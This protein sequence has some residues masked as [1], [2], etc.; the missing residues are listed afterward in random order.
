[1]GQRARF[2]IGYA[3]AVAAFGGMLNATTVV[4]RAK[5]ET[6]GALPMAVHLKIKDPRPSRWCGWYM[7][8][9]KGVRDR[10]FNLAR[11]WA[12]LGRAASPA[13]GVIVVWPHH[14]GEIVRITRPGYAVVHSGNDGRAVRTRERRISN[15]IAFR[16]VGA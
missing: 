5:G 10:R 4:L 12:A 3:L 1:M 6:L 9:R 11:N 16:Q 8:Q 14:V 15:A 7:R 2:A 13:P